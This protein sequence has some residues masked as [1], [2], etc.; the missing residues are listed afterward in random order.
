MAAFVSAGCFVVAPGTVVGLIPW[1]ITR[2][3]VRRPLPGW[4]AAR[5]VG[6]VL[7]A[8]GLVPVTA[9]FAEFVKAG[10]TSIPLA[11]TERP[12]VPGFNRYVRNPMHVGLLLTI[13]RAGAAVRALPPTGRRGLGRI[14]GLRA[15]DEV[16]TPAAHIR[17]RIRGVPAS[18]TRLDGHSYAPLD[19]I[20]PQDR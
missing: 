19:T 17:R 18:R 13:T 20:R 7:V 2:W 16:P 4:G 15:L 14:R 8:V 11:P 6:A 5:V 9:A 3:R 12:V 1:L 10:R